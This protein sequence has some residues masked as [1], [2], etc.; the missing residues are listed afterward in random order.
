MLSPTQSGERSIQIIP[1]R[2][3]LHIDC[4]SVGHS[5]QYT[6]ASAPFSI[7]QQ[8]TYDCGQIVRIIPQFY[9]VHKQFNLKLIFRQEF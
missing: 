9:R 5:A 3:N 2:S 8:I 4:N 1:D 7:L 6:E